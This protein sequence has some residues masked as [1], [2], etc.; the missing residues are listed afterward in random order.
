MRIET[1]ISALLRAFVILHLFSLSLSA[2][3][4][5]GGA[6]DV[7]D[8]TYI[9]NDG[10]FFSHRSLLSNRPEIRWGE[11]PALFENPQTQMM[12]ADYWILGNGDTLL[13][14]DAYAVAVDGKPYLR[15]PEVESPL[16]AFVLLRIRGRICHF[17]YPATR[18]EKVEVTAYNPLTGI[19]FRKGTVVNQEE[20]EMHWLYH[21]PSGKR[22][23]LTKE[24]LLEWVSDDPALTKAVEELADD[25]AQ[26]EKYIKS[27]RIYDDRHPFI[28]VKKE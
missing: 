17:S 2:Q 15:V 18:E 13:A 9:F 16:E 3:P 27:I 8:N 25:E 1:P 26:T 5:K 12:K 23:M 22:A 28:M 6:E 24:N 7:L 11:E 10:I 19:P 4:Q 20:E 14:K 21:F